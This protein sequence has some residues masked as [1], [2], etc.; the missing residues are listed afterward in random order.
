MGLVAVGLLAAGVGCSRSEDDSESS[1][2]SLVGG[3]EGGTA[4]L[5]LLDVGC[6]AVKVGP[7]HFVTAAR[8]VAYR[9]SLEAGGKI[10]FATAAQVALLDG[11]FADAATGDAR[12]SS[13]LDAAADAKADAGDAGLDAAASIVGDAGSAVDA[14]DAGAASVVGSFREAGIVRMNVHPSF[15]AKCA[16]DACA[17]G[18]TQASDAP[19]IAIFEI[20]LDTQEIPV[21]PVDLDAI[22]EADPVVLAG[23]GCD[24]NGVLL[25][26]A[27][28]RSKETIAVPARMVNH[29]GSPY[30]ARPALVGQL[31]QAY[32]VTP[33]SGWLANAPGLCGAD[34][35]GAL[36]RPG[37]KPA[38]IGVH[39]TYTQFADGP[40]QLAVTNVHTRLDQASRFKIGTWLKGL[41]AVTVQSCAADA[42]ACPK[43]VYE[44]GSPVPPA[45][46]DAGEDAGDASAAAD[47]ATG[48]TQGPNDGTVIPPTDTD[49]GATPDDEPV[50]DDDLESTS[51]SSGSSSKAKK[52]TTNSGCQTGGTSSGMEFAPVF[53]AVALLLARRRRQSDR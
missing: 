9:P 51:S 30:D 11:G 17:F 1:P 25:S 37:A 21:T 12:A 19:D 50:A 27:K 33:G 49:L 28:A 40:T 5:V 14:G 42:G 26:P 47:G 48:T 4:S 31:S 36:L 24:K 29:K 23:Y 46:P 43:R 20:D 3:A 8:C 38:L 45:A 15:F 18:K 7:R 16:G 44:G 13:A 6:S 35:G 32:I 22:G 39:S 2:D 34:L 52:N 53:A 10:R 41:G